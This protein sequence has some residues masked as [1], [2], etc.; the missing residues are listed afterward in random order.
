MPR[1]IPHGLLRV[2]LVLVALTGLFLSAR[3]QDDEGPSCA[4]PQD[5]ARSLLDWLQPDRWEPEAAARCLDLPPDMRDRAPEVAVKLKK[6]LDARGLYVPTDDLPLE[7]DY[8]DEEG[9]HRV[10]PIP[11]WPTLVI[12]KVGDR[13]V[14]ARS[15]VSRADELYADTF[16]GI[17][18]RLQGWL[19]AWMQGRLLGMETWQVV[20]FL[21]LLAA[22]L[23]AGFVAQKLLA[24]QVL[25][26]ARRLG[27]RLS[28][29]VVR[30]TRTP[31]TWFATGVIFRLGIADLQL[32]VN[33]TRWLLFLANVV[34]SVAV[35]LMASRL[36]DVAGEVLA[37]RA[38]ATESKMDDQLIPLAERA[39]K[40]A[41]WILGFVFVVQ[42]MGVDV[43]SVLAG[44]GIG[45]LAFALAAKD[46]LENLFGGIT[47]FMDRPFQIGDW[48]IIGGGT[49]GV[50]EEVGFR[51]TRVRTFYNS[52]VAVPNGKV[53]NSPIDNMGRRR[54][55]RIKTTLGL[56]YD[57][58]RDKLQA[59]VEGIRRV[60]DEHPDI[61]H[62]ATREIHFAAFG[63]SALEVMVYVF[64][65][66][67]DWSRELAARAEI[68][69][70]F[71]RVAEEVG[72][73]FAFPSTSVYIEQVPPGFSGPAPA[74]EAAPR[75]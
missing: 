35:V 38:A 50:V 9:A 74:G 31:L 73:K 58:P 23:A 15:F 2:A 51:T 40:I 65:D 49:E 42:N 43:G 37:K 44:L 8:A 6:V 27:V 72:V 12:E 25:R 10:V 64:L 67:P 28:E 26:V 5:A 56:T 34:I 46:T 53:A 57:T 47:V 20:Y 17:A 32:G 60:V 68:Y 55:R 59:F 21:L 1:R 45:G 69:T 18:G 63:P 48:V 24:D 70:E 3:A 41:T 19:P 11:T 22:S 52:Q 4:T 54:Y 29:R 75:A 71:M 33:P 39:A 66:V 62:D 16:S 30:G 7:P 14:Y 13:W 61:A 36:I